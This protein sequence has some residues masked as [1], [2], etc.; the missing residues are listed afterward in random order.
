MS[1]DTF[2]M[3]SGLLVTYHTCNYLSKGNK[4][5]L[6]YFYFHRYIRITPSLAFVVLILATLTPR[7]GS[8]PNWKKTAKAMQVPCQYF[9]WSALLHVQNYINPK[10]IV[11]NYTFLL[12]ISLTK[13]KGVT[14]RRVT[15]IERIVVNLSNAEVNYTFSIVN[16]FL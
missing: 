5:K 3:I 4:F 7:F 16:S 9:W 13:S 11:S 14:W 1:V 12:L 6:G 15:R 8:G 10:Y 2:F